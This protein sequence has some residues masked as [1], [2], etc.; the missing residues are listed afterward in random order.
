MQFDNIISAN[1]LDFINKNQSFVD[2]DIDFDE[3]FYDEEEKDSSYE[4]ASDG[5]IMS[6]SN[7][8]KV[9]IKYISKITG[10]T[11][12]DVI[13]ELKGA[14]FQNPLTWNEAPFLGWETKEE[15]L[16][17]NLKDKYKI[18]SEANK[19]YLGLFEDNLKAIEEIARF[20][21][22]LSLN[23]IYFTLGSPWIPVQIIQKFVRYLFD[24]TGEV[25][26]RYD[27]HKIAVRRD[28]SKGKWFIFF[29][30]WF[31]PKRVFGY[32]KYSTKKINMFRLIE[33]TMNQ[34]EIVIR[35]SITVDI[36]NS[37]KKKTIID[38]EETAKA[39]EKQ[40]LIIED[41]YK[42][43]DANEDV[44]NQLEEAYNN[45]YCQ[46]YVRHYSGSFLTFPNMSKDVELFDYQKNAVARMLFSKNTLLAHEVGSGKTYEMIAAGQE[47]LRMNLSKK[48]M[49]VV[50]NGII[51]QWERIF[52]E[53]YPNANVFVVDINNFSKNKRNETLSFMK[54]DDCENILI[55]Y[56]CFDMI[57]FEK[58]RDL[59]EI[60]ITF[61][62]LNIDRLFVDEAHNYKNV[63]LGSSINVPGI[64][65]SGSKKCDDMMK[66][67]KSIQASHQGGGVVFATGTPITNS[68]TDIFVMQKY[69]QEGELKLLGIS[70]LNGWLSTFAEK[71][72][73]F[74]IDVDTTKF[75][76][77]DRFSKF[78]NLPELSAILANI[79]DFHKVNKKAD[80]PDFNGYID[81]ISQPD[82]EFKNFL[83]HISARAD[84]IRAKSPKVLKYGE[85][86]KDTVYDNMLVITSDGRK[87]ALDLRLVEKNA[88]VNDSYKVN[89]C[90][91]KVYQNYLKTNHFK[92]T[93]LIFCDVSIPRKEFNVYDEIKKKLVEYGIDEKEIQFIHNYKTAIQREKIFKKV[94]EGEVRVLLGSTFK[95]GTGVNV[96]DK[97]YAIHHI[98]I[99]WRPSDVIQRNGRI[100]R[101]GNT[102]KEVFIYRYVLKESF[103]AY[104]W[105]I[106]ETK[107]NIIHKLLDNSLYLRDASD[108]DDTTLSYA[109]IKA[110][111]IGEP[112]L[113]ERVELIN[114]IAVLKKEKHIEL[115][116]KENLRLRQLSLKLSIP[117]DKKTIE[118]VKSDYEYSKTLDF[119]LM[120]KDSKKIIN[121]IIFQRLVENIEKKEE[122][123]I[124]EYKGFSIIAP[125][126]Q[127]KGVEQMSF[128]IK[129]ESKHLIKMNHKAHNFIERIEKLILN[130]KQIL[131]DMKMKLVLDEEFVEK[132]E[133][134]LSI[135]NDYDVQIEAL[136]KKLL[137]IDKKLNIQTED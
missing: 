76:I 65:N 40:K 63:S 97:L 98:D 126:Y 57:P 18:A 71:Q 85:T 118:L 32:E 100:I 122:N 133:K 81:I 129:K 25:F 66:K 91:L 116:N 102:N 77:V 108:I 19:K 62:E 59:N 104:S 72:K 60:E 67:V 70:S 109:E 127:I 107:Q 43:V 29:A 10:K 92:G 103:D 73:S 4:T 11:L 36:N 69:L 22:K 51:N 58:D 50:P 13:H 7:L 96:Q 28:E 106:L 95:L 99:P 79:I 26:K 78:H 56:S 83:G 134:E 16:S 90:A 48:N 39:I 111:A 110:L 1:K 14:I 114:K 41:F 42:Y 52:A 24:P 68:L 35:K 33:K 86:E 125:A 21:T 93:Q 61:N 135:G 49:Y 64:R 88:Q 124:F 46:N 105:Q 120:D 80:L 3:P 136:N 137:K 17:G 30:S 115:E 123:T 121:N 87:A 53:M 54:S 55:T 47:M 131:L 113:K 2:F 34:E 6:I 75:K 5:L 9:D 128:Y 74:E 45:C 112:L 84:L 44:K 117:E 20:N 130:L 89:L 27:Y 38:L 15:Y 31:Y 101:Y 8:G 82:D 132:A 23:D 37:K 12:E 119:S 94:R